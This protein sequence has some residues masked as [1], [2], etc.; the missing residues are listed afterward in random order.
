MCVAYSFDKISIVLWNSESYFYI[1]IR[2][3]VLNW[4]SWCEVFYVIDQIALKSTSHDMINKLVN[5]FVLNNFL[6]F[7][8]INV[9]LKMMLIHSNMTY[10][11]RAV[12][13]VIMMLVQT[14]M[15]IERMI[16][17]MLFEEVVSRVVFRTFLKTRSTQSRSNLIYWLDRS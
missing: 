10:S 12:L 14:L 16:L 8:I 5:W 17:R 4:L 15:T 13:R 7:L 9:W 1:E 11:L 2:K 3:I 6:K